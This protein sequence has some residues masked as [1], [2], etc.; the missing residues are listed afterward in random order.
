VGS[1]F[2]LAT[3]GEL[4]RIDTFMRRLGRTNELTLA[5]ITLTDAGAE[6][7]RV[8]FL[9]SGCNACHGNAGANA[10]FGTGGNRNFN[11]GVETA[12]H[13]DLAGF[14]RDGGLGSTANP[15]GSF[16]N[17]TFNTPPLIEAA[18]TGPFFHTATT[19]TGA[20][21][22]N[23]PVATTIEDAIAFYGTDAFRNAPNGNSNL[24]FSPAEITNVGKFLRALNATFNI[25][26]ARKRL[27]AAITVTAQFADTAVNTQRQLMRLALIDLQDAAGV[28]NAVN[29]NPNQAASLGQAISVLAT[30]LNTNNV[31]DRLAAEKQ[32]AQLATGAA[33]GI[34]T[35]MN[36]DIGDGVV[37]F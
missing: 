4:D 23:T 26:M 2:R 7:G 20:T 31:A 5:N 18:D 34:G 36:Y 32:A 14:A 13:S 9:G 30:G 27:D 22:F 25:A 1:D 6:A 29:L 28:L 33:A 37:A 21:A 15:D 35:N 10:S 19:V 16:G 17:G 12:R 11:T 3:D 8:R 24:I